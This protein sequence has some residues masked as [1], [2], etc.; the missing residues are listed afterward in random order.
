ML[1][2]AGAIM[3]SAPY[4]QH[5][6]AWRD[7][8]NFADADITAARLEAAGLTA[9]STWLEAA[10]VDL[11]LEGVHAASRPSM[12]FDD[13]PSGERIVESRLEPCAVSDCERVAADP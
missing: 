7:P 10:P 5:F 6:A 8:W 3:A 9:I 2:H 4:R 11:Q 12:P 13:V 1:E